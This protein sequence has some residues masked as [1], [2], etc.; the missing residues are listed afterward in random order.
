MTRSWPLGGH[1][2]SKKVVTRTISRTTS[3][4]QRFGFLSREFVLEIDVSYQINTYQSEH[5][6]IV[7]ATVCC[8][9][10]YHVTGTGLCVC[11]RHCLVRKNR[12]G[13]LQKGEK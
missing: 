11:S 4:N 12:V 9:P 7:C 2:S 8:T 6:A 3:I 10:G 1:R 13:D 5:D